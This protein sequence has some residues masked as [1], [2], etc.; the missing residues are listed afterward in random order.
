MEIRF[1][2]VRGSIPC[3]SSAYQK[4]GGDTSCVSVQV[5]GLFLIFDAGSGLREAGQFAVAQGIQQTH[6]FLSHMH[7]DHILG[8]PFYQPIWNPTSQ[9]TVHGI[10]VG[11][12]GGV[13]KVL[14]QAFLAP[15]FPVPLEGFLAQVD[16]ID[17]PVGQSISLNPSVVIQTARLD[18]PN[19]AAGYR[20]SYGHKSFCYVTDTG[21]LKGDFRQGILDLI[22]GSDLVVYDA[23]FTP[24]DIEGKEHWGHSTW[25]EGIRLCQEAGAKSLYLFHHAPEHTDDQMD[26][27]NKNAQAAWNHVHVAKQGMVVSL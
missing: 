4:Y 13:K 27:I 9:M 6:L 25:A 8:L 12:Y 24:D 19:G 10:E 20:L 1:W 18:H 7:M 5:D 11:S 16:Y 2:G 23:S 17:H 21:H 14:T 22:A 15:V 3:G 26:E